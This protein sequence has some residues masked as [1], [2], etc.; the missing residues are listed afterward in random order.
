MSNEVPTIYE[1]IEFL[2]NLTAEERSYLSKYSSKI[3]AI[4]W[5]PERFYENAL[6]LEEQLNELLKRTRKLGIP[7]ETAVKV[8]TNQVKQTILRAKYDLIQ[9]FRIGYKITHL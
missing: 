8:H 9:A 6:S 4:H 7:D 3:E 1:V 5:H 2:H